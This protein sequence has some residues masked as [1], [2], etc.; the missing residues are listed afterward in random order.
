MAFGLDIL[1]G[2]AVDRS[3]AEI[4]TGFVP[5]RMPLTVH[6]RGPSPASTGQSALSSA[7]PGLRTVRIHGLL[8]VADHRLFPR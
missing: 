3:G 4:V 2:D 6:Q 1:P 5:F 7:S 8:A